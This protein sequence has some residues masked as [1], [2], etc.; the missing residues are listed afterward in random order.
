MYPVGKIGLSDAYSFQEV[1]GL[2]SSRGGLGSGFLLISAMT[3]GSIPSSLWV[4]LSSSVHLFLKKNFFFLNIKYL[5]GL[6]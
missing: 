6:L 3:L 1:L 5:F 4:S 2:Y